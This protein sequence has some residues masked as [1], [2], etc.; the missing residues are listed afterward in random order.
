MD[1]LGQ[2]FARSHD[3]NLAIKIST[4]IFRTNDYRRARM[5][6]PVGCAARC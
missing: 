6:S 3:E 1:R 4:R 2:L 5:D